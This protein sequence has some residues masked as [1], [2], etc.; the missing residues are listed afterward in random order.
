[1][2]LPYPRVRALAVTGLLVAAGCAAPS[3]R[4]SRAHPAPA[5]S[6]TAAPSGVV[7]NTRTRGYDQRERYR[8]EVKLATT[9]RFA[10]Q[11]V[12]DF[13]LIG[14]VD[15]T[16]VS[17]TANEA[18]LYVV[19]DDARVV[20]RMPEKGAE[21]ERLTR[22]LRMT[23]AF[24]TLAAGRFSE[25]R[26]PD[27]MS[28]MA[29]T[30][31]RQLAGALQFAHAPDESTRYV[32][33]EH[34][35]TGR[36]LA[37]YERGPTKNVWQKRKQRY[38]KLLSHVRSGDVSTAGFL[39]EIIR[40]QGE[41]RLT[42]QGLPESVELVDDS[43]VKGAQV[44]IRS[45]VGIELHA[46]PPIR[47]RAEPDLASL[48]AKTRRF[49]AEEPVADP[50]AAQALDDARIGE[51]DF[52]VI[53]RGLEKLAREQKPIVVSDQQPVPDAADESAK[54]ETTAEE[55]RLFG[56]LAALFRKDP[57]AV[58]RAI[59]MVRA[60]LPVASVLMDA[61]GSA[62][63]PAAHRALAGLLASNAGNA[64][65]RGRIIH[66]LARVRRPTAEATLALK[67]VLEKEP[68]QAGAL[69]GL[70]THARL[71]R[72]EGRGAEASA[73][74][75]LL[76][77][78]LA[79]APGRLALVTLLRAIA[80][81]GYDGA[82][83]RVRPYLDDERDAVRSAAVRAL[84]SMRDPTVDRLIAARLGSDASKDVRLSAIASARLREPNDVLADAVAAAGSNGAEPHVR[85]RAVETM[86]RWLTRRPALRDTLE[87]IA[88]NDAE[89]R[90][91]ERARQA[92]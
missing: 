13:D 43:I 4:T 85:Y 28:P 70:G 50:S 22:E 33:E 67:A 89:E 71:L 16:P 39:P 8:Y 38:L 24:F 7:G 66:S 27:G 18:R 35:T 21:L 5:A 59:A 63:T 76:A 36:H 19:M 69:Y 60:E 74:G 2:S 23:G 77:Q 88:R 54:R 79:R 34:D 75:E 14:H 80:N 49:L 53:V 91:R 51:L 44:P 26:V 78:R 41:V 83:A 40:S 25:L 3:A 17:A 56:A 55:A 1:M 64:E 81:S 29:A 15:L 6:V 58:T 32:V 37:E 92:L 61:L 87:R 57:A 31:Y 20:N 10:D 73:L 90:V 42:E 45:T 84:Q 30:V 72:D 82:L 46:K 52:D 62:S 9:V 47:G 86:A 11:A 68:Y 48:L 12:F 65:V